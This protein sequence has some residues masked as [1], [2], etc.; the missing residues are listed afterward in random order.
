VACK[1]SPLLQKKTSSILPLPSID[2]LQIAVFDVAVHTEVAD[3]VVVD[4]ALLEA[5]KRVAADST[6][7]VRST[8]STSAIAGMAKIISLL[9][10]RD[11]EEGTVER[12]S[13]SSVECSEQRTLTRCS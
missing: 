8:S 5:E 1:S 12:S 13:L 2:V 4:I 9:Y 3:S 6:A 10:C 11:K 7:V